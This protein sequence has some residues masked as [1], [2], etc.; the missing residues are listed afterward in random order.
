MLASEKGHI[1][2]V[3]VLLNDSRVDPS[4]EDNYGKSLNDMM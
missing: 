2:I 1:D 4:A 3:K